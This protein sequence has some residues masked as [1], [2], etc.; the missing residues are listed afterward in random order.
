MSLALAV[1]LSHGLFAADEPRPHLRM[2][3]HTLLNTNSFIRVGC[4]IDCVFGVLSLAIF[5][6]RCTQPSRVVSLFLLRSPLPQST[7]KSLLTALKKAKR[8]G[9]WLGME[10]S[11]MLV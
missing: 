5:E 2:Q 7:K 10:L 8:H 4:H 3:L 6:R 9:L 1:R 11:W